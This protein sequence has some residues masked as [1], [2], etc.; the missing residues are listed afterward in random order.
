ME[1]SWKI[2]H[3]YISNLTRA[4]QKKTTPSNKFNKFANFGIV[5]KVLHTTHLLKLPDKMY[6]YEMDPASILQ[7]TEWIKWILGIWAI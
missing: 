3:S 5:Q 2:S 4:I 6:E 1:I 7:D